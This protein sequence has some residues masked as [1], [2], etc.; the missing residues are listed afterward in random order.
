VPT[1]HDSGETPPGGAPAHTI[2]TKML[3]NSTYQLS[4]REA[5]VQTIMLNSGLE[6]ETHSSTPDIDRPSGV[7]TI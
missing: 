2:Q 3:Q 1:G 6:D 4:F 7:V 5:L